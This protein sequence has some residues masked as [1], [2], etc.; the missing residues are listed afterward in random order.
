MSQKLLSILKPHNRKGK[1][2]Y[3]IEGIV[4]NMMKERIENTK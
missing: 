3:Q 4:D 2:K 1:I